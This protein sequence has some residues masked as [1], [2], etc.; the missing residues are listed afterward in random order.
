MSGF[1]F[2]ALIMDTTASRFSLMEVN[3]MWFLSIWLL[4][5]QGTV[6]DTFGKW[7]FNVLRTVLASRVW[8]R[9]S[10]EPLSPTH[11]SLEVVATK[12]ICG[13]FR[14]PPHQLSMAKCTYMCSILIRPA[15]SQKCIATSAVCGEGNSECWK[16]PA[17][18]QSLEMKSLSIN[19][20]FTDAYYSF[21]KLCFP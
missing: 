16:F 6:L 2:C 20:L 8:L 4:L 21:Q 19:F 17:I 7:T 10:L 11:V 3:E 1:A 15:P 12:T 18:F 9:E 5:G 14:Y 13:H